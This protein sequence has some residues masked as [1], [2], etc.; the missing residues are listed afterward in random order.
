MPAVPQALEAIAH[1][2]GGRFT[3]G[4]AAVDVPGI[5]DELGTRTGTRKKTVEVSAAAAG[6]GLAFVLAGGLLSGLWF[7]RIP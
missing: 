6:G 5:Y 4:A 7:R 3:G 1:G 2:S